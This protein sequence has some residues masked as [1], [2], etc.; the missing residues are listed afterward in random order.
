MVSSESLQPDRSPQNIPTNILHH[1][2][3]IFGQTSASYSDFSTFIRLVVDAQFEDLAISLVSLEDDSTTDKRV[4]ATRA[5]AESL[6][7]SAFSGGPEERPSFYRSRWG[8]TSL[9]CP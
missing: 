4:D 8:H 5:P 9:R 1:M 3:F 7:T 6:R 2:Q